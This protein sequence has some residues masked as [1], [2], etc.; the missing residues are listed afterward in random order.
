MGEDIH[1]SGCI[2]YAFLRTW[3]SQSRLSTTL[4]S[5]LLS[6]KRPFRELAVYFMIL[7]LLRCPW[8]LWLPWGPS[9]HKCL[10]G[11]NGYC[12]IVI[13]SEGECIIWIRISLG[14]SLCVPSDPLLLSLCILTWWGNMIVFKLQL[15]VRVGVEVAYFEIYYNLFAFPVFLDLNTL[16]MK[17]FLQ[18][19]WK[20]L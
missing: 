1:V 16:V 3:V 15:T 19:Y 13:D 18:I 7:H 2:L 4:I 10:W 6:S 14:R 5:F 17:D 11:L 8:H 9:I 20:F 12:G